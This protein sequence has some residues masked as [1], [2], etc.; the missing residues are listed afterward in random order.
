LPVANP[1]HDPSGAYIERTGTSFSAPIVAGIVALVRQK[2]P[3]LDAANVIN[4]IIKTAT[5]AGGAV[6]NDTYGYGIINAYK[7]VTATVPKVS[8]NPLGSLVS[9]GASGSPTTAASGPASTASSPT[10]PTAGTSAPAQ[11]ASQPAS[12][13]ASPPASSSAD[14]S[15]GLGAGAWVGI[16]AIVLVAAALIAWLLSRNRRPPPGVGPPGYGPPGYRPGR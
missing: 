5:P 7:A 3:D 15:S 1:S 9:G 16:A 11:S 6:P 10:S 8:A 2:F 12:A 14:S 13:S 4:R